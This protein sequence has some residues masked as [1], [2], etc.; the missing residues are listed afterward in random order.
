[1][2][3]RNIPNLLS[4]SRI[5]LVPLIVYFFINKTDGL[6]FLAGILFIVASTTDWL[7]GYLARKFHA[8]SEAGGVLDLVADKILVL[9][10]LFFISIEYL[11]YTVTSLSCLILIREII[12]LS[13]R[14]TY[15]QK[16]TEVIFIGKLKTFFQMF[17]IVLLLMLDPVNQTEIFFLA[18]VVLMLSVIIGFLSLGAYLKK[19]K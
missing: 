9:V 19:L 3:T 15:G 17:A 4:I 13:I 12:I 5:L 10:T 8:S 7:D 14:S 16:K 6:E 2:E 1:M 18:E 11:N